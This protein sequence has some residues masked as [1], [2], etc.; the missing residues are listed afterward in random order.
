M[1]KY[2]AYRLQRGRGL[3]NIVGKLLRGAM[4]ILKR[5]AN[6]LGPHAARFGSRVLADVAEGGDVLESAKK[7][8]KNTG[9]DIVKAVVDRAS[10]KRK[11]TQTG[12][13]RK[14]APKATSTRQ[15]RRKKP[16]RKKPSIAHMRQ[17]A[18]LNKSRKTHRKAKAV[19]S[20]KKSL[21]TENINDV[22]KYGY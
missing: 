8:A 17:P 18:Q 4:P 14:R 20:R 3:G 7:Y 21:L 13:G 1:Y 9:T 22:F 10:G 2:R 6:L 12:N 5:G 11:K 15:P 16:R 19:K